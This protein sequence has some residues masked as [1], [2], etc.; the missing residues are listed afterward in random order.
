MR[1]HGGKDMNIGGRFWIEHEGNAFVGRGRIELLERIRDSGSI[2][3]AAKSM[4]M[5]Y[6]AAWDSVD[7]MNRV[8]KEAVVIR[9]KGGKA[10]GGTRLTA[11]G[12]GLID[13]YR[14]MEREHTAFLGELSARYAAAFAAATQ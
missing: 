2:S 3:E 5:A 9:A 13:A 14:S 6:K 10:G 11:Y 8:S 4:K 12:L 1:L 7:A